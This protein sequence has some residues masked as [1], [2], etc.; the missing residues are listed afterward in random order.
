MIFFRKTAGFTLLEM[1]L[2]AM[3][4]SIL[5]SVT[6]VPFV[7]ILKET[8]STLTRNAIRQ[9]AVLAIERFS[10]DLNEAREIT[11]AQTSS[12][13]LWWQD[14]DSDGVRDADELITFSWDGTA[15]NPFIR[16]SVNIALNVNNFTLSYR[17]V[18]NAVLTP[19]PDLTLIQ[20]DSL[21]RVEMSLTLSDQNEQITV[22]TAVTPRNLR[23]TRGPW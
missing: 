2:A 21:R 10:R 12:I 23:Q 4:F 11:S 13:T 22:V 1:I 5:M 20:R 6:V 3:A 18:N 15:G 17:D 19:A 9:D 14:T 16:S 7:V 8:Q